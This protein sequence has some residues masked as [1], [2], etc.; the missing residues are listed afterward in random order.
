[1]CG[2]AGLFSQ[3]RS[4]SADQMR[5][6]LTD[7][8]R[9]IAHRGP[10]DDGIWFDAVDSI[11]FSHRRLSVIDLS[12][13]GH[14]PMESHCGRFVIVY[15]GEIYNHLIIRASLEEAG[16]DVNWRGHSDTETLITAIEVWGLERTLKIIKGMFAFALWDKQQKALYLARDRV[17][18]KPLY[19]GWQGNTFLL[20][21]ELKALR[22]H[23]DFKSEVDRGA[24]GLFLRHNY[25]PGPY[26]IY[27]GIK[28]LPAGTFL[29]IEM[30]SE[31]A[32]QK[33][34]EKPEHY[35]DFAL[36]AKSGLENPFAGSESEALKVLE[37]KLGSVIA[38]Q[39]LSDVPLGALLSG[40][41]DSSLVCALM[42]S[43][44]SSAIKT[45]TIGFD[46][47]AY[48]E[49]EHASAVAKHL[50]TEHT[51]LYIQPDDALDLIPALPQM[52]DEPFADSSQLPTHL[53]MHMVKQH[54]SVALSGDG[55]D[56]L[57]GGYNRYSYAPKVW[58]T[59]GRLPQFVRGGIAAALRAMPASGINRLSGVFGAAQLG[60]K[61][62]KLGQKLYH[63]DNIDDLY[64]NLVSEWGDTKNLV[65][66]SE[67]PPYLL[68]NREQWPD[69]ENSVE[70]MMVLDSLFYLPDD[71][72]VKVDRAAMAVSLESRA[73]FLD[74]EV[75]EF[76][77]QL[78]L[79][80]KIKNGQ[81]KL[82]LRQLLDK[83]VP[84]ELIERPKMGFGI[85]LDDWLRG[86][87]KQWAE[88]LLDEARL[89]REGY[90]RPEPIRRAW[91]QHLTGR[92]N[93]GYRLWSVLMFQ[94]WLEQQNQ[95]QPGVA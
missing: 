42:Q 16:V 59:F 69:M 39:M 3:T 28:K 1:V 8:G 6:T 62:H 95:R 22:A 11:G 31:A 94:S 92:E 70:R 93:Y 18:E 71:I 32:M 81:G 17:G 56:E 38:G 4:N 91:V 5:R 89:R 30:G 63:I 75:I 51:E 26:S 52:Y 88:E 84:R 66:G 90:F 45:F 55:G 80:M 24:L 73:P 48:N 67:E 57:F 35:W 27:K 46:A 44:N 43:Q 82:I 2:F 36:V 13:A 85:P 7:M 72:L 65:L 34:Q 79:N 23:P 25:V 83:Y 78:P 64:V 87:L 41:V 29:K 33:G 76:A 60:D 14:Q 58:N 40:G 15:N 54:V 20:G 74:K 19:Y 37:E 49:A 12:P 68:N 47:R 9:A 21:S 61:A 10:D 53:V 77:W 86:P 50:G